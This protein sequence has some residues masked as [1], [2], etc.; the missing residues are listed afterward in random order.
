MR[1]SGIQ[2]QYFPRLHYFARI[3]NAD[4]FVTRD[5]VQFVRTHKYP[6]GRR[7]KSYQAHTPIKQSLGVQFLTVPTKHDGLHPLAKTQISYDHTWLKDHLNTIKNNYVNSTN[8]KEIYSEIEELLN[9]NY[10]TLADLNIATILWGILLLLGEKN[11]KP[12][13]LTIDYV[14][15]KLKKQKPFRLKE[16][17]RASQLRSTEKNQD[18]SPNEKIVAILKEIGATED[19]CGGTAVSAYVDQEL[20]EKNG[21]KVTPQD[22]MCREYPQL[23]EKQQGFIPNLSIIDLLMNVSTKEA[24]KVING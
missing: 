16:I 20:F 3:L 21:I 23:F 12:E 15:G 2:P 14:N 24:V 7:D 18:L 17:K 22:W 10:E 11:I 9:S 4:V 8:F 6:D 13:L 19:Y 1:H 5:E